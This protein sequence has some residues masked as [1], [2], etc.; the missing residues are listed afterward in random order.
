MPVAQESWAVE[1]RPLAKASCVQSESPARDGGA[2]PTVGQGRGHAEPATPC[3]HTADGW[4]PVCGVS[5]HEVEE[6]P[7]ALQNVQGAASN[8]AE[9]EAHG[10]GREVRD[11]CAMQHGGLALGCGDE[12]WGCAIE[13]CEQ[14]HRA[15]LRLVGA[16]TLATALKRGDHWWAQ[17]GQRASPCVTCRVVDVEQETSSNE[18]LVQGRCERWSSLPRQRLT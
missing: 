9:A 12:G 13:L 14:A 1:D 2:R 3:R 18:E 16:C 15:D 4:E 7:G 6:R 5:A 11:V 17:W 8:A 10:G